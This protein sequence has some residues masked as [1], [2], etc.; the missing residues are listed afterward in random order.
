MEPRLAG[1]LTELK[2]H[3]GGRRSPLRRLLSMLHDYPRETFV[4]VVGVAEKYR[5]FDLNRLENM[6]LRQIAN[7]FF[8][9]EPGDE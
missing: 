2:K 7:D 3:V 6:V 9:P 5:L 1:Y 8:T 4:A